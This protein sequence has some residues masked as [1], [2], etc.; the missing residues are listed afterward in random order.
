MCVQVDGGH[1][2]TSHFYLTLVVELHQRRLVGRSII[3]CVKVGICPQLH[4]KHF[5]HFCLQIQVG[6]GTKRWHRYHRLVRGGLVSHLGVPMQNT[7]SK[8]LV[9]ACRQHLHV[10]VVLTKQRIGSVV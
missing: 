3:A 9:D 10:S 2:E 4:G 8:L 7:C 5:R 1:G 6:V